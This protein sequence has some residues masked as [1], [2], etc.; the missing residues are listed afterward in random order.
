MDL[1]SIDWDAA[2]ATIRARCD[3]TDA[4]V[5]ALLRALKMARTDLGVRPVNGNVLLMTAN[6]QHQ[7]IKVRGGCAP[8][9]HT[10][11]DTYVRFDLPSWAPTVGLLVA[12][13]I[14]VVAAIGLVAKVSRKSAITR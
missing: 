14:G 6:K 11:Q 13:T 9:A 3:I 12:A 8:L 1:H 2:D 10:Y 7:I 5:A 4:D